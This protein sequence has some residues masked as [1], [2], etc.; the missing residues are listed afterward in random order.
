M[1]HDARNPP[2][3]WQREIDRSL[4]TPQKLWAEIYELR[5]RINSYKYRIQQLQTRIDELE[6]ANAHWHREP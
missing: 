3:A 5:G 4:D 1:T 2:D 6:S